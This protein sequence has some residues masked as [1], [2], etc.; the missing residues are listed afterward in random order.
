MDYSIKI[1]EPY[2]RTEWAFYQNIYYNFNNDSLSGDYWTKMITESPEL[3][4]FWFDFINGETSYLSKYSVQAIG[5]RTKVINDT[6]VKAISYKEVPNTIFITSKEEKDAYEHKTGYTYIQ[7][8]QEMSNIF[9]TSARGKS[10]KSA[11][12]DLIY[13]HC[14]ATEEV[15]INT[16]PIYHLQPNSCLYIKNDATNINGDYIISKISIPLEAKKTMSITATKV[17]PSII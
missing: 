4:D 11:I 5:P 14:Y 6:T 7:L 10:A 3:L 8:P 2:Y 15:N 1:N 12:E 17:I 9:V 13:Q 16:I